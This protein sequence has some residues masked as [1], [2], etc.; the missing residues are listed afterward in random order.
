M[1][2]LFLLIALAMTLSACTNGLP[3]RKVFT[4]DLCGPVAGFTISYIAYGEG[5][6]VMIPLSKVRAENV[7]VVK[8]QPLDGFEDADVTVTGTSAKSLPWL[9]GVTG[10]YEDL[11]RSIYPKG[12]LEVGC[13]PADPEGTEYKFEV[14][15]EKDDVTNILDPRARIV[16]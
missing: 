2:R 7:F 8:L 12:S 16:Q 4:S 5:K 15:V 11:P 13:V 10:R 9:T 6:M 3:K 1:K 14:K